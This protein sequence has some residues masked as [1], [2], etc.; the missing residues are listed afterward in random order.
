MRRP[1]AI[2]AAVLAV[3]LTAGVAAARP[4]GDG[5]GGYGRRGG[6]GSIRA[7]VRGAELTD[8][9][10]GQ[11]KAILDTHRPR[12]RQLRGDLRAA[13]AQ[14][15]DRLQAPGA[16]TAE[17]LAPL[18]AS[19]AQLRAQLGQE[20]LQATL[21][22]RA[23]LTPEQLAKAAEAMQRHRERIQQWRQRHQGQPGQGG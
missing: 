12:L 23:L 2:V 15:M 19:V 20:M 8:E 5:E 4:W 11:V 10:K 17:D 7:L 21:E 6:M 1:I 22:V 9:Q 14:L 13:H 3:G 16:V 18:T